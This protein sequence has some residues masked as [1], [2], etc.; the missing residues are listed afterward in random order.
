M[1]KDEKNKTKSENLEG[2]NLKEPKPQYAKKSKKHIV[3]SSEYITLEEFRAEA[4]KRARK[5]LKE[6][7]IH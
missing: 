6:H 1:G 7:G 5:L 2:T 4:K 3:G